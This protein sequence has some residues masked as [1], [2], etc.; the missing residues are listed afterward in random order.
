VGPASIA[1][2]RR[3]CILLSSLGIKLSLQSVFRYKFED[4]FW[5]VGSV[6]NENE[7]TTLKE[8]GISLSLAS[9]YSGIV[10]H[11]QLFT[12]SATLLFDLSSS[13]DL[14]EMQFISFILLCPLFWDRR[15]LFWERHCPMSLGSR[16]L[17]NVFLQVMHGA[18]WFL[19]LSGVQCS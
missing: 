12:V 11:L 13:C 15:R 10:L 7:F 5:I 16:R 14:H 1:L 4:N 18:L 6:E 8:R 19:F 17:Q 9:L 3:W 2:P